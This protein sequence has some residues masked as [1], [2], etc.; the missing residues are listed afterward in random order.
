M[1]QQLGLLPV[2]SDPVL[3]PR[4]PHPNMSFLAFT[5]DDSVPTVH[6]RFEQQV[7]RHPE[8][9]AIKATDGTLTYEALNAAANRVARA[10]LA[11]GGDEGHRSRCSSTRAPSL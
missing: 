9:I 10:V 5:E 4:R 7:A 11:W 3:L 6:A 2:T 8:R 1:N